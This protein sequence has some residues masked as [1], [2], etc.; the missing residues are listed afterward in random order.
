MPYV[1]LLCEAHALLWRSS[2]SDWLGTPVWRSPRQKRFALAHRLTISLPATITHLL[3]AAFQ[4]K[5]YTLIEEGGTFGASKPIASWR[6]STEQRFWGN[7][8]EIDDD[9]ALTWMRQSHYYMGYSYSWLSQQRVYLHFQRTP[10]ELG[11]LDALNPGGSKTPLESAWSRS[12]YFN[13]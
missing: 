13:W 1:D 3:E 9:A 11:W 2:S 10:A 8:V 4:R 5:V 12:R 7:A 6:K